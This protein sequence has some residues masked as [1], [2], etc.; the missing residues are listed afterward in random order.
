MVSL[1]LLLARDGID[2]LAPLEELRRRRDN[3]SAPP[4]LL[5]YHMHLVGDEDPYTDAQFACEHIGRYVAA[6]AAAGIAEIGFS[7]HVYRFTVARDWV[8]CD[9]WREEQTADI[10]RYVAAVSAGPATTGC[11]FGS[12]WRST[13]CPGQAEIAAALAEA[14]DWD[15]LL[16]SYHWLGVARSTMPPTRCGTSWSPIG[17]AHVR[18]RLLR[19]GAQRPLRLD[20]P[21]R[22]GE[23]VRAPAR[24][25]AAREM[26]REMADA[27]RDGGVCIE[28]STAG[29]RKL[30]GEMYP[31]SGAARAASPSA[32]FR[33]RWAPTRTPPPGSA[34]LHR[35][36]CAGRGRGLPHDHPVSPP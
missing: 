27:A 22:S 35:A 12:A 8:D 29:L 13:G 31:G 26:Y 17:V 9:A 10:G 11:R 32:A 24:P 14:I 34:A 5:D 3:I 4:V 30:V 7:D 18:G 25:R 23:G 6:A 20:V 15:Y 1:M 36:R 19:G 33:S 28:V 21:P 16:G 2:P